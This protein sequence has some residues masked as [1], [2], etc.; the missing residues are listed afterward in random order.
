MNRWGQPVWTGGAVTLGDAT[1]ERLEGVVRK[2]VRP[3]RREGPPRRCFSTTHPL[4][5]TKHSFSAS[6][7]G[8]E[9]VCLCRLASTVHANR[10]NLS[11]RRA[12]TAGSHSAGRIGS[13]REPMQ[14]WPQTAKSPG[15]RCLRSQ[16]LTRSLAHPQSVDRSA[17]DKKGHPY[18]KAEE[19]SHVEQR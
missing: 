3:T 4:R 17:A 2:T 13:L 10:H 18:L 9:E 7:A 19:K 8:C 12:P 11:S 14:P 6:L 16:A 1:T 15:Q 5:H